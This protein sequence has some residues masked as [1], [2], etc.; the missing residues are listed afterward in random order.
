MYRLNNKVKLFV[1]I[2]QGVVNN[3]I[4]C[5]LIYTIK[6]KKKLPNI[7]FLDWKTSYGENNWT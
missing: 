1:R 2:I 5:T 3:Y 4:N 7:N 6:I